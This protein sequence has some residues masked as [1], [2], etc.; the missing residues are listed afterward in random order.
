MFQ[1]DVLKVVKYLNNMQTKSKNCKGLGLAKDYGC[2]LPTYKR[3]RGLCPSC[4]YSFYTTN[5]NGKVI[6]EKRKL[7]V[8]TTKEKAFKNDLREK[9]KTLSNWKADLQKEINLI[10]RLIDNGHGC[11]A[12]NSLNGKKNAGHY[13]GIGANETLRF[14]LENIWLQSEHSNM[15]K[16]GDILRYQ[17]GIVS[18]YGKDYLERLNSFKSIEPI[19]LTIDEIKDKIKICREIIKWLK[20]QDRMFDK[21]ERLSLRKLFNEKIGIYK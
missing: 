8:K 13:I 16:S 9:L 6:F 7:K 12:T 15:W 4:L 18:L 11:I 10:I 19:K 21:D 20:E 2:G 5:E 14:H 3:E 1:T 17:D